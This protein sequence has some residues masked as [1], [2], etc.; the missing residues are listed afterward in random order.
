MHASRI[1]SDLRA[2]LKRIE[3]HAAVRGQV[4]FWA[5]YLRPEADSLL[6]ESDR[7]LTFGPLV[8]FPVQYGINDGAWATERNASRSVVADGSAPMLFEEIA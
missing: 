1:T 2:G 7:V 6:G 4:E 3:K 5:H 8:T